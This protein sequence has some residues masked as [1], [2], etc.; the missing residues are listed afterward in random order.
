MRY[1]QAVKKKLLLLPPAVTQESF[2]NGVY[3]FD[4]RK[5]GNRIF[6]IRKYP[7]IGFLL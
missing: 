5:I 6:F 3:L 7:E 1:K 4:N 2:L